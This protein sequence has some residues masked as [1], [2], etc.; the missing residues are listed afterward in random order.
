[1]RVALDAALEDRALDGPGA[2]PTLETII[3]TIG[4]LANAAPRSDPAPRSRRASRRV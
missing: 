3:E 2:R 1:M 4:P